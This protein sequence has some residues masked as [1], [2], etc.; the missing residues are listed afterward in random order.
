MTWHV[1]VSQEIE[2]IKKLDGKF[3]PFIIL[4]SPPE[5]INYNLVSIFFFFTF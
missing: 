3:D 5:I 1:L 4:D 2:M